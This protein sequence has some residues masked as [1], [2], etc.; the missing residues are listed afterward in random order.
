MPFIRS[1]KQTHC[2]PRTGIV[3]FYGV[4]RKRSA[5]D[6]CEGVDNLGAETRLDV[7]RQEPSQSRII[8]SPVAKVAR[9][10]PWSYGA[11][12]K[13]HANKDFKKP[14]YS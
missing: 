3:P 4:D 10:M 8:L 1:T 2:L 5:V 13:V 7:F 14:F 6:C 11:N 9:H 12:C